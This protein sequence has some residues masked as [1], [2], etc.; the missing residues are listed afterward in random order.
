MNSRGTLNTLKLNAKS[1]ID[2]RLALSILRSGGIVAL[3]TETVYGLAA[4]ALCP[5]S[6]E[7]IF[8]AKNRPHNNPLILHTHDFKAARGIFGDL[9]EKSN[10]RFERLAHAFWPGP[11]TMVA[12]RAPHIPL[13]ATGGLE[14]VAVRIPQ[15]EAS[16]EILKQLPFPLVMPSANLSTRPSP[17]TAEHVLKTL[18]GRIDAVLD[19]GACQVGIESSVVRIDGDSV[20]LLRLGLISAEALSQVL[21]EPVGIDA[22]KGE[23]PSCPGQAYVH[24]APKVKEVILA[25]KETFLNAWNSQHSLLATES[26]VKMASELLGL[27]PPESLTLSLSDDPLR[28]AQDIYGALYRCEDF[29][30]KNVVILLPT[31]EGGDWT[32][33][34]DRLTRSSGKIV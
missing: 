12:A 21:D 10:R 23:N 15:S 13:E 28:F 30:E 24:Y 22:H 7:K 3:P 6:I 20:M 26:D 16:L 32:A 18:G 34:R 27:R 33:L 29:P 8:Q 9:D 11:L 1:A 17:T 5:E 4:N 14:S 31:K 19:E 2:L 25:D